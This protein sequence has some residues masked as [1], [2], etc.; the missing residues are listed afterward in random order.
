MPACP[1]SKTGRQVP[2][3]GNLPSCGAGLPRGH[4]HGADGGDIGISIE[5]RG[6]LA[7][8]LRRYLG[9]VVQKEDVFTLRRAQSQFHGFR[10]AEISRDADEAR[11]GEVVL[12][13]G[14]AVHGAVV[15]HHDLHL[16]ARLGPFERFQTA[17][18]QCGSIVRHHHRRDLGRFRGLLFRRFR[19]SDAG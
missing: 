4:Q 5:T 8:G 16:L 19:H 13:L 6:E 17:A 1:A 9:V 2:S 3:G 10:Q 18:Q 7:H 12:Q 15:D 11:F 14:R